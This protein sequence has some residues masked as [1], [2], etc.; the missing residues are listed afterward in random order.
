MKSLILASGFGIRL[1]PLTINKPKGL[2]EYKGK[3]LVTHI[4]DKIPS[5]IEIYINTNK[6]YESHFRKLQQK[7]KRKI[8][9]CIE[10]VHTPDQSL[11]AVGSLAYWIKELEDDVLVIASDNYFEFDLKQFIAAYDGIN[12]LVAVYKMGY[13]PELSQYGIVQ[14]DGRRI[15]A[16]DEKP[17]IPATD[18]VAT[19]CYI[20]PRQLFPYI[21]KFASENATSNLGNL[22][23]HI[24]SINEVQAYLFSEQWFDMGM[25]D[26][27][28][29]LTS[30]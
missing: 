9:L 8:N 11:G 6:K 19:A 23:V 18:L 21:D 16:L 27:L 12:T 14:L 3:S 1:H 13:Q 24:L 5:S 28:N 26:S 29:R 10:P 17:G 20:I 7:L 30:R 15:V 22:I 2:F 25:P 4:V